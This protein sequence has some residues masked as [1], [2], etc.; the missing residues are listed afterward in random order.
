MI[1]IASQINEVLGKCQEI[2]KSSPFNQKPTFP[3]GIMQSNKR[4]ALEKVGLVLQLF[5]S[6]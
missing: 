3:I 4:V 6:S 1:S 2:T 5:K